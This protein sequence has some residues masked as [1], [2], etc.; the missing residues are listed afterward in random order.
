MFE[1]ERCNAGEFTCGDGKCIPLSLKCDRNY[2][3]ED[4]SDERNCRKFH[5]SVLNCQKPSA[6]I[7]SSKLADRYLLLSQ[8][9]CLF[10]ACKTTDFKCRNGFCIPPSQRCDGIRNCQDGSDEIGC[11]STHGFVFYILLI[12]NFFSSGHR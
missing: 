11:N 5:S 2:D 8:L 3:C 9:M 1:T 12:T 10:A 7:S 4:K 6:Q